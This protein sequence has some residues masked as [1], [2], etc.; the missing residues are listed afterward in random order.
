MATTIETLGASHLAGEGFEVQR[1]NNFEIQIDGVTEEDRILILA[2]VSGFLPHERNEVIELNY[3][4]TQ[5]TVAGAAR[6]NNS[7]TL[8]VRDL[9]QKDIEKAIDKWRAS[10]YDKV[11]DQIGFAFN[12]K[13]DAKVVQY[14]PD[15]TYIRS[16]DLEGVWPSEVDYGQISYD[17]PGVKTVSIT[18]QYDKARINRS[19]Y[20]A[21]A[22]PAPVPDHLSRS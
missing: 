4:N 14:A 2:V 16:W 19:D 17:S 11:N 9:L 5:I 8:V 22:T 10:V 1:T 6:P 21:T 12:Y 15:G 18:L 7:G 20:D 3:G 13:K